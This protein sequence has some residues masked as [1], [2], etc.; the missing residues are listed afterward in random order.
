MF[1]F[2]K[3]KIQNDNGYFPITVD[4]HS[5]ILPG[6]DDG[7]PDIA[8]S[9]ELVKGLMQLGLKKSIATP[10]VI[11]DLYHNTPESINNALQQLRE[12]LHQNNIAYE[13]NAAAE[14]L[15]DDLFLELLAKKNLLTLQDN[16]ILTEFSFASMPRQPEELSFKIIMEGYMPILA[17]PER[18]S[19][20]HDQPKMYDRLKELGFVLQVNLLS[21]TGY[22][23]KGP[24]KAAKYILEN[25]LA[26]FVGTDLQHHNHLSAFLDARNHNVFEPFLSHKAWIEVL[27]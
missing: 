21:L 10:H 2:K 11:S 18:Y 12:A 5:H 1:G 8:T 9:L 23:G 25:G 6:I 15:M 16:L 22:Y 26:G 27:L 17:H 7:S 13:V 4:M 19:Y 24:F 20:Y 3:N 14:Y